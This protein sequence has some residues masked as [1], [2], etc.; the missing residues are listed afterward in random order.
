MSTLGAYLEAWTPDGIRLVPLGDDRLTI[1]RSEDNGLALPQEPLVSR[2]HAVLE[3]FGP[4]WCVRDLGSR[5]GTWVNGER[6][7]GER[8]LRSGDEIRLGSARLRFR[9]DS[10]TQSGPTETGAPPPELTRRERDVLKALCRPL[11]SGGMFTEPASIRQMAAEL[12]VTEAAIKQHL[13]RLYDKFDVGAGE[14]RRRLA[15]ANEALL[16]GAVSLAELRGS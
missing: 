7:V 15:L 6:I 1:G 5:N 9:A 10:R 8:A 12:V 3:R 11:V 4:G 13:A 2:L 16:R 14:E